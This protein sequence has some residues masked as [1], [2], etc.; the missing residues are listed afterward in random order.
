[1]ITQACFPPCENWNHR[2]GPSTGR[3]YA[4]N[5]SSDDALF[6]SSLSTRFGMASDLNDFITG[7]DL[8][9][10]NLLGWS[11][12]CS[13]VWSYLDLFGFQRISKLIFVDEPAWLIKGQLLALIRGWGRWYPVE[14]VTLERQFALSNR[15]VSQTNRST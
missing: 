2:N 9:H 12:G 3:I 1:V 11:M 15:Y 7:L 13:V 5:I 6:V 8:Q 10:I 4:Y 14:C